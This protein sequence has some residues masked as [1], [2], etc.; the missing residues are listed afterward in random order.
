[1]G[2][3]VKRVLLLCLMVAGAL[4]VPSAKADSFTITFTANDYP[5]FSGSG[6]FTGNQTAPGVYDIT[7]V[8]S[9]SVTDPSGSSAITGLSDYFGSDNTLLYP[10]GGTYFTVNGLSFSLANG[11]DVNLYVDPVFGFIALG[12]SPSDGPFPEAVSVTVVPDVAPVPEPS[13][14]TLLGAPAILGMAGSLRRRFRA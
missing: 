12:G 3:S 13:T 6:V 1:M 7:S 2:P 11:D 5:G 14:L 9:G 10:N 8:L 4:I